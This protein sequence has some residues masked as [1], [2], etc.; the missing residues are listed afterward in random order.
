MKSFFAVLL[1][2]ILSIEGLTQIPQNPN[3]RDEDDLKQGRWTHLVDINY[4][5]VSSLDSAVFYAIVEYKNDVL[6]GRAE[7]YYLNGNLMTAR[8]MKRVGDGSTTA[9][10]DYTFYRPDG[11]KS[12]ITTFENAYIVKVQLFDE[13]GMAMSSSTYLEAWLHFNNH[14]S[15]D[16]YRKFLDKSDIINFDKINADLKFIEKYNIIPIGELYWFGSNQYLNDKRVTYSQAK[17][18]CEGIE[19][20]WRMPT[21]TEFHAMAQYL[22]DGAYENK[23]DKRVLLGQRLNSLGW[24]WYLGKVRTINGFWVEYSEGS[25]EIWDPP[26][27]WLYKK[28]AHKV[29][30]YRCVKEPGSLREELSEVSKHKSDVLE[31]YIES[32]LPTL[33]M[34]LNEDIYFYSGSQVEQIKLIDLSQINGEGIMSYEN[35]NIYWGEFK[36]GKLQGEGQFFSAADGITIFGDFEDGLPTGEIALIDQKKNVQGLIYENGKDITDERIEEQISEELD[37]ERERLVTASRKKISS[38]K[39]NLKKVQTKI[40]QEVPPEPKT[41]EEMDKACNRS[42]FWNRE[43]NT[44]W[45]GFD[46]CMNCESQ[47]QITETFDYKG[48]TIRISRNEETKWGSL[49]ESNLEYAKRTIDEC[50]IWEKDPN[51]YGRADLLRFQNR[52]SSYRKEANSL[53]TDISRAES[54]YSNILADFD[55]SRNTFRREKKKQFSSRLKRKAEELVNNQE[56][57]CLQNPGSCKCMTPEIITNCNKNNGPCACEI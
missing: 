57:Y 12:V 30:A 27:I 13:D 18:L 33:K 7:F 39:E 34:K 10:G 6:I 31:N 17:E 20:G 11:T 52:M 42:F 47:E 8:D 35:G 50:L 22:T 54:H 51:N 38:L 37:G 26:H 2:S 4:E 19:E 45:N 53:T 15:I 24:T 5:E 48:V 16:K 3:F 49:D 36:S 56:I 43:R 32:D 9:D 21:W 14:G 28:K 55:N 1:L 40:T 25:G 44:W 41:Y 29:S 46:A 23:R